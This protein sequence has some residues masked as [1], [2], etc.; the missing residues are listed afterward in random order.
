MSTVREPGCPG[1]SLLAATA[2][3]AL[4]LAAGVPLAHARAHDAAHDVAHHGAH[5]AEHTHGV[6]GHPAGPLRGDGSEEVHPDALHDDGMLGPRPDRGV[7]AAPAALPSD[8]LIA[9]AAA[10]PRSRAPEASR[11]RGPPRTPPARAPPLD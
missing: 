2:L 10:V 5:A 1:R 11:S 3:A 7:V 8:A 6:D 9:A 4:L